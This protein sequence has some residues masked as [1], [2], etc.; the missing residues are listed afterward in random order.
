MGASAQ[1]RKYGLD[2]AVF[3]ALITSSGRHRLAID[4][5]LLASISMAPI[6]P[7]HSMVK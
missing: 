2:L 5:G 6:P 7:F 1:L 4:R 3:P